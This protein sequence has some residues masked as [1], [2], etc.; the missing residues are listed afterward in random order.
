[1]LPPSSIVSAALRWIALL[2]L[3]TIEHAASIIRSD[4]S[5]TDLTQ[6]QYA[7]GFELLKSISFLPEE[8][9]GNPAL[10]K[11]LLCLPDVEIRQLLF[12]RVLQ[13]AEPVWL[14]DAD[15]LISAPDE[16]PDDAYSFAHSLGLES[17]SA[18]VGIRNAQ[19][20]VDS[21]ERSRVGLAGELALVH[22]LERE[23]PGST[24]HVSQVSDGFGYD[25][26]FRHECTDWH[27]EVKSTTRRGRLAIHLSR[28]EQEVG[29]FDRNWRLVAVGL[30]SLMQIESLA[31]VNHEALWR[32]APRDLCL[33]A[34][35]ESALH[36]V[37]PADLDRGLVFLNAASVANGSL[38]SSGEL[39]GGRAYFAWPAT[40][41][42]GH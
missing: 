34:K 20:K 42:K 38:L 3:S 23:W 6:T 40:R 16:V 11:A 36:E 8:K 25:V 30:D 14:Q 13:W 22:L 1:M 32:R 2:R 31:T 17:V 7:L 24:N 4:A 26:V 33:E 39:D 28:H 41:L 21:L 9:V 37:A 35:W 27:L 12:E 15:I 29:Q 18:F 19:A 5:H 10:D